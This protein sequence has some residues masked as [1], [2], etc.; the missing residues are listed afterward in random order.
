M[1]RPINALA[2]GRNLLFAGEGRPSLAR[3]QKPPTPPALRNHRVP[4]RER[5]AE[6]ADRDRVAAHD[7]DRLQLMQEILH[8][9]SLAHMCRCRSVWP[10]PKTPFDA[11]VI[12]AEGSADG[13]DQD[14]PGKGCRQQPARP[15]QGEDDASA[16]RQCDADIIGNALLEAEFARRIAEGLKDPGAARSSPRRK[17]RSRRRRANAGVL[18]ELKSVISTSR[19]MRRQSKAEHDRDSQ[20]DQRK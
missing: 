15:A 3:A 11:G 7:F 10:R 13:E 19:Q 20:Q 5:Q 18:P 2:S 16:R 1:R 17:G 6:D 14:E 4:S 12:D 9:V 8:R